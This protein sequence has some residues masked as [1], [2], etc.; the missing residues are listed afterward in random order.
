MAE[1]TISS[2][3]LNALVDE[4]ARN[5]LLVGPVRE[6][7]GTVLFR[8]VNSSGELADGYLN[9]AVSPKEFFFSRTESMFSFK[10][11]EGEVALKEPAR[12]LEMVLFGVRPCDLR[13]IISLDPVF[14]GQ[15]PDPYYQEKRN[16]T[17]I[18]ALACE[19]PSARCF[20][21]TYGTG[22]ADGE[23]SD[24]ML[25]RLDH[26]YLVKTHTGK[27]EALAERY[28]N[29]FTPDEDKKALAAGQKAAEELHGKVLK[30]DLTGVKELLDS[31]FDLPYWAELAQRCLN[32]GICTY[33]CP[34][35]HCFNIFD[36][37][38]GGDQGVRCRGWDSCM[39]QDFTRMAGGHNPRPG[40]VERVRNRFM[41]KL[42][43]HLDRYNLAG[44]Y[45]CG[46][47]AGACPVNIDI[48]QI[49][50]DLGE[51]AKNE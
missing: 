18:V 26:I 24:I 38:R 8:P 42:K 10:A 45:G 51:V 5:S 12:P 9:S 4:V 44:C 41:H 31:N 34:T 47:C 6:E 37:T 17:T 25:T 11:R 50:A 1:W 20:C 7:E 23:G 36:L 3:R 32:C 16:N 29:F 33:I 40:K 14:G 39:N 48:R 49:I 35:C 28:R 22:P 2:D 46:R 27:G 21:T 30:L 19:S 43:Y 15:F 13:G